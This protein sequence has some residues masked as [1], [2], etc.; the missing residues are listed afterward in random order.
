MP[1]RISRSVLADAQAWH[2]RLWGNPEL[3]PWVARM[4][5]APAAVAAV[6]FG[7]AFGMGV[8]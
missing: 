2:D 5:Y 3:E 7:L 4:V 1:D 8:V 6:F